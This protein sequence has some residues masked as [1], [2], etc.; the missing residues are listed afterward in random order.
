MAIAAMVLWLLTAAAGLTLLNTGGAA[1]RAAARS[2]RLAAREHARAGPVALP[3]GPDGK[4]VRPAPARVTAPPGEHPLVEFSHPAL[5]VAG[6][7]CWL[8]YVLTGYPAMAWTSLA[9]LAVAIGLGLAWVARTRRAAARP[10]GTSWAFPP[11]LIVLHGAAVAAAVTL[12]LLTVLVAAR[13]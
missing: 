7:A 9:I 6:S 13:A 8:M 12:S 2:A 1:R 11:R 3:V 4:P 10:A 5:A